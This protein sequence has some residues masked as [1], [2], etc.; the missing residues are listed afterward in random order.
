MAP[1]YSFDKV[2]GIHRLWF[3]SAWP[4]TD[5]ET[6]WKYETT[7]GYFDYN[8]KKAHGVF[9]FSIKSDWTDVTKLSLFKSCSATKIDGS[10]LAFNK[11]ALL[12]KK[13]QQFGK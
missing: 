4:V 5:A 8:I 12:P 1:V 7:L 6:T 13:D 3:R 9:L 2:T 11:V 10:H